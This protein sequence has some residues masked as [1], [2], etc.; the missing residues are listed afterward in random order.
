MSGYDVVVLGSA[1]LDLV[2]AV[3]R[4]PSPGET[5]LASGQSRHPGGKGLNQAV[6]AARAGAGTGFV[7]ALGDDDA[8]HGLLST[9]VEAGI[10]DALVRQAPGPTGTALIVV[11]ADGNNTIV[12]APGANGTVHELAE[13]E[14]RAVADATVAVTQL[15]IPLSVVAEAAAVAHGS[16]TTFVLNAAPAQPLDEE[17]LRLVDVLVVNEHE[18]GV[19]SGADP[20]G[21]VAAAERLLDRAKAVVVTLGAE[22]AVVLTRSE[23]PRRLPAPT[24]A[25]VDT[26]GAGDTFT[27]VLAAGLAAG[28]ALHEAA[29]RAVAAASISTQR[30][31][32]VPSIPTAAQVDLQLAR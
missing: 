6:A 14:R 26:T 25:V 2:Y 20:T 23:A 15:E 31:G 21:P 32:A 8:G 22:G 12:V 9:M 24:V 29:V 19:L 1:N 27:G 5:V 4:I 30:H 18:A 17:L 3:E 28:A 16:A 10:D 13:P 11:Q 7:G